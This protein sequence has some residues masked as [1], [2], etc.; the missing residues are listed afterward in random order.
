VPESFTQDS[1]SHPQRG[2]DQEALLDTPS[3][4][5]PCSPD[6][7]LLLIL[8]RLPFWSRWLLL[9]AAVQ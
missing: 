4:D 5:L 8:L 2:I 3:A 9:W 7:L 6:C 1:V